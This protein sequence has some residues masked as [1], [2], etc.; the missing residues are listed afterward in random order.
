MKIIG[1]V[2]YLIIFLISIFDLNYHYHHTHFDFENFP[3][4]FGFV[5]FLSI[6]IIVYVAKYILRPILIRSEEYYNE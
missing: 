6:I 4:F 1:I 3:L 2:F 5:G